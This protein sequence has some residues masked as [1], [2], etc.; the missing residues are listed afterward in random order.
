MCTLAGV[1]GSVLQDGFEGH[2]EPLEVCWDDD[3]SHE[4]SGML[5]N[6]SVKYV[7]GFQRGLAILACLH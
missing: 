3:E 7:H 5:A 4:A 2:R 1:F 6:W